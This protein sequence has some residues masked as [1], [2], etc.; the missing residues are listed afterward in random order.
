MAGLATL[1]SSLFMLYSLLI[2]ARS[3]M[4][5]VGINPYHPVAQWLYRL[6]EP[7]LAPIRNMMPPTGT[8]DWSPMIAIIVLIILRQFVMMILFSF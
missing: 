3:F 5:W 4:P 8:L 6:T 7:I 2:V 1:I